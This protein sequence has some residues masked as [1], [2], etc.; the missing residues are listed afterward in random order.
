MLVGI[1]LLTFLLSHAVPADPVT[2]SLGE[3]AAADPAVVAAF[4]REWGLDRSLPEQYGVYLWNLARGNFGVS[5]STR[6]PVWLDLRQRLPATIELAVVAMTVS[7]LIGIP[8]G[9]LSAVKRDRLVDQLSRVVSLVGVSMPIFWL[10]LVALVIFYARLGWAPPP[11]RLS[12][13]LAAPPMVTGFLLVDS[14][15]AGQPAVALDA[16]RHLVLPAAVLSTYNLGVLARLMRGSTLDVLGEDYVR[17]ARAK[18]L[19]EGAVT[20]RHAAR[21]ALIPVVTVVGRRHHRERVLVA[22]ARPLRLPDG[23]VPRLPG[24]HGRRHRRGHRLR[25]RQPPGG[26]RVRAHRPPHPGGAMKTSPLTGAAFL[27]VSLWLALAAAAP[28]LA[29]HEP[30]RQDIVGRLAA[31]S[32]AHPLGTDALGRDILSRILHGA[33]IS[34][35]VGLAAVILAA[36]LGALVGG[37]AGFVGHWLD[38]VA[39]RVTDLMLAFP[40]VILALVITAAL[41]VG[42]RNAVIAIMIAWWPTYARLVRGLVLAV[43]EREYV[44]VAYALGASDGRVLCR[45]I[46]PNVVSSIVVLATLDVGHAILTFASLSFLGL[47]PPPEVPEWGSMIAAGRNYLDEWWIA[48]FPGLAILSLTIAFNVVGDSLRDFLDP[49]LRRL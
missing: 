38:D 3:Q 15:L 11:G 2:A 28:L 36:L 6:Q 40:T 5:I 25:C 13:T 1:T 45:Y 16:L 32:A 4:R 30:L 8:L 49:R 22:G 10:G 7:V 9:V 18:G 26:R 21:N 29:P 17:T 14:M 44:Q 41:G 19:A 31:P 20:L 39:M 42:I 34:I 35:P 37:L 27:V 33:R 43:R 24:D 48:T 23:D 46:A 47:G 12:A